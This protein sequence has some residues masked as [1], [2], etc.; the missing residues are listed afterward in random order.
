MLNLSFE[1]D[2]SIDD[3]VSIGSNMDLSEDDEF[4]VKLES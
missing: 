4:E 2:A 3:A 1:V